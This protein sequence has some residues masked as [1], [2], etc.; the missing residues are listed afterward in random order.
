VVRAWGANYTGQLGNGTFVNSSTPVS[1]TSLSNVIVVASGQ[2]H[3][4]AIVADGTVRAWGQ[5]FYGQLGNG[6]TADSSTPVTVS[7][8]A[9]VV[10]V[11]AGIRHSL[12]LLSDGSVW[13]WGE[14][15]QAQ[16]GN[17][18]FANSLVPVKVQGVTNVT[19][20]SASGIH[21]LALRN[22]GKVFRWGTGFTTSGTFSGGGGQPLTPTS[23]VPIEV[24]GLPAVSKIAAGN[25]HD[26]VLLG[27]GTVRAWGSNFSGELGN[28]T[29][30]DSGTP[31]AVVQSSG[32]GVLSGVVAVA[33]GS[34][35]S[36]ALLSN[37][38]VLAWGSNLKGELG[39]PSASSTTS[40]GYPHSTKPVAVSNLSIVAQIDAG[41]TISVA[42]LTD[43]TVRMWG[44]G[45][46]GG[47]GNAGTTS[48]GV[49]VQ[50]IEGGSALSGVS[51]VA[52]KGYHVVALKTTG[53]SST[54]AA[55]N[56]RTWGANYNNGPK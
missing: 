24:P 41:Q 33:A 9:G 47:L 40:T 34:N 16:L 5:N 20:I 8:L 27:D 2:N 52:L 6:N 28:G 14:G 39:N 13:A 36:L 15:A 10:A 53:T 26:L 55:S 3:T 29:H 51:A 7:G 25:G 11:A 23:A 45:V 12:A 48:S 43:G 54:P 4:L 56:L 17:N 46:Y 42:R 18:S 1:V 31:V 21:S 32:S 37:G 22:D 44:D 30:T 19:A 35:H 38:T 49:P 50:V